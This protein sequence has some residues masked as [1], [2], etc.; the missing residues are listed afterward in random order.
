[1]TAGRIITFNA[2]SSTVKVGIF[3]LQLGRPRRIGK[4]VVDLASQPL[5]LRLKVADQQIEITLKAQA[6]GDDTR[7]MDEMFSELARHFDLGS[8]TSAGHRIVHGGD[9]FT[10]PVVLDEVTL[11]QISGLVDLAPLHQPQALRM[12]NAVRALLPELPQTGSFDTAF[13]TTVPDTVRRFALPR[14]YGEQ[15]VKRYGFHGLSY[16]YV[17]GALTAKAPEIARGRVV[18]AHLGSGASLCGI[19]SGVSRDTSMGFS[20]L[21][22][23]P[24]A[25]RPGALDP[26]V[27]LH[28][29][30]PLGKSLAEVEDILY[31]RSGLLGLSGISG[32]IRTLSADDRA[33]AREA[34][35]VFTH[36]TAGEI[37]R[38]ASTLQGLDAIVFT[39][40]I[41]ENQ[42]VIRQRIA[43]R[44]QWLGIELDA[45]ANEKNSERIS[46]PS[47]RI[48]VHVVP[49]DEEQVIAD[50][51][52]AVTTGSPVEL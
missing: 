19:E 5:M 45:K 31:H 14:V 9:L 32:D 36:R 22:G 26:G 7:L 2:G 33:E 35:D 3:A 6:D 28:M 29:L 1:M 10:G 20:T 52:L 13:H 15:G 21:D 48:A 42:P 18:I 51:S 47:S 16:Q 11:K 17:A 39:A 12:I 23:I 4:A 27:V 41:G 46:T 40:G 25:T 8:L 49:T 43:A 50:E 44:L 38:L 30:G 37:C 24:M 34:I